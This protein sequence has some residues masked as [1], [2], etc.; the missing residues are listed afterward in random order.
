M[1]PRNVLTGVISH[2][3]KR[4]SQLKSRYGPRYT[5]AMVGAAFVALFSPLPGSVLIAVALIIMIAE[6]QRAIS[7]AGG[8]PKARAKEFVMS[9]NCDVILQWGATPAQLTD[10]GVA[11]WRWCNHAAGDF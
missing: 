9:I 8:F 10:L 5:K 4:Y 6:A 1:L 11:L 7:K 2:V 3:K